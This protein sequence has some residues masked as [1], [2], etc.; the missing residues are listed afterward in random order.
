MAKTIQIKATTNVINDALISLSRLCKLQCIHVSQEG[1]FKKKNQHFEQCIKHA[2]GALLL[3][4]SPLLQQV[5][6]HPPK[7]IHCQRP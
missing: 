2:H 6:V 1:S 4:G 3:L 5:V 7:E